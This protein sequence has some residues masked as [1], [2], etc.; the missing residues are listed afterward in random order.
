MECSIVRT[1]AL[2]SSFSRVV[3]ILLSG[4]TTGTVWVLGYGFHAALPWT[5]YY[6]RDSPS[7]CLFQSLY[8][9]N[10]AHRGASGRTIDA[11]WIASTGN[12]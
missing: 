9:H 12:S 11:E 2:F 6:W 7:C 4:M 5:V 3:D 1:C 8:A 10:I